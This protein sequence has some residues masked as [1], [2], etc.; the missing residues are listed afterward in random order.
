MSGFLRLLSLKDD[1]HNGFKRY[2]SWLGQFM[3]YFYPH[4][5]SFLCGHDCHTMIGYPT[6][7]NPHQKK[8]KKKKST[9]KNPPFYQADCYRL[10]FKI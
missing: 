5:K 7:T 4:D 6:P 1:R 8:K 10:H 9:Q 2:L 3:T